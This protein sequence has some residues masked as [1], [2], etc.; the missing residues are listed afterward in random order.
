MP[1]KY[2]QNIRDIL[3]SNKKFNN[4]SSGVINYIR[5]SVCHLPGVPTAV[6]CQITEVDETVNKLITEKNS[7]P[8]NC[9]TSIADRISNGQKTGIFQYP[10]MALL[11]YRDF[12]GDI[13]DACGGSLIH[14]R[15]VLTAAHCLN[16]RMYEL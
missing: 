14:E 7:L 15:Y 2:C 6:C 5:R 16:D 1:L 10:W 9:G 3:L 4:I 11:R 12:D 13:V 8:K